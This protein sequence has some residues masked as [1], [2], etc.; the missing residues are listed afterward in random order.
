M[1]MI[2]ISTAPKVI[3][4]IGKVTSMSITAMV[5]SIRWSILILP[6]VLS[7]PHVGRAAER[8]S[9]SEV[10]DY[11]EVDGGAGQLTAL[12]AMVCY[13]I[14]NRQTCKAAEASPLQTY[15]G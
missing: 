6:I 2:Y 5:E 9:V 15:A 3:A 1:K 8:Y 11:E 12:L 4:T 10:V 7:V 14:I 13:H